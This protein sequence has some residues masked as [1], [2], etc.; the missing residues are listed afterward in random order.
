M[1]MLNRACNSALGHRQMRLHCGFCWCVITQVIEA[2]PRPR[3]EMRASLAALFCIPGKLDSSYS[4][5]KP[6]SC[7]RSSLVVP[8]PAWPHHRETSFWVPGADAATTAGV[9]CCLPCGE[10]LGLAAMTE[11]V[12]QGYAG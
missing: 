6:L 12:L 2:G 8:S 3:D 9:L 5:L 1:L 11:P 4:A 10:A 7:Q